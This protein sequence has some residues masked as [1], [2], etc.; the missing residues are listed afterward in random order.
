LVRA[1][2]V[3]EAAR[4]SPSCLSLVGLCICWRVGGTRDIPVEALLPEGRKRFELGSS[5]WSRIFGIDA[6]GGAPHC[7]FADQGAARVTSG[8]SP[9][10]RAVTLA[11]VIVDLVGEVGD[12]LGSLCQVGAP[13]GMVMERWWNA[14]KP[15]Q[16]S[17]VD[18]RERWEAPVEY[19]GHVTGNVEVASG[20][21]RL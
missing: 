16:R 12:Q 5:G 15:G 13:D 7:D 19:G 10:W 18:R 14:G 3:V 1:L 20:G 2:P 11:G 17:W 6:V 8:C 4:Q 21:G 9:D